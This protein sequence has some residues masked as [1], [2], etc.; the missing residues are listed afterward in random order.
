MIILKFKFG[1]VEFQ[2]LTH[3]DDP[4]NWQSLDIEFKAK[5]LKNRKLLEFNSKKI[6]LQGYLKDEFDKV[7]HD[8]LTR[9]IV[10]NIDFSISNEEDVYFEGFVSFK[11]IEIRDKVTGF[12]ALSYKGIHPKV[13]EI[14]YTP[15]NS[16]YITTNEPLQG[17][18]TVQ[19]TKDK[20]Y[21]VSELAI[22]DKETFYS[23]EIND[24]TEY[25]FLRVEKGTTKLVANDI[26]YNIQTVYNTFYNKVRFALQME[27]NPSFIEF[28]TFNLRF[29]LLI[30]NSKTPTNPY[31]EKIFLN[32]HTIKTGDYEYNEDLNTFDFDIDVLI[33]LTTGV[34]S[35]DLDTDTFLV[36][37]SVEI[38]NLRVKVQA[39]PLQSVGVENT[40]VLS[41][42]SIQ[43]RFTTDYRVQDKLYFVSSND[44]INEINRQG[45]TDYNISNNF[46]LSSIDFMTSK[47]KNLTFNVEDFINDIALLYGKSITQ[48]QKIIS[49][50]EIFTNQKSLSIV[51]NSLKIGQN[52]DLLFDSVTVGKT[53]KANEKNKFDEFTDK[54]TYHIDSLDMA[55]TEL[56]LSIKSLKM[57]M[58]NVINYISQKRQEYIQIAKGGF[59]LDISISKKDVNF[60]DLSFDESDKLLIFDGGSHHDSIHNY[61][62]V[63]MKTPSG[64]SINMLNYTYAPQTVLNNWSW[65]I[66][67]FNK[68]PTL[69]GG[70][71]NNDLIVDN[72]SIKDPLID[73]NP[74][75]TSRVLIV[76]AVL[77][78]DDYLLIKENLYG[79]I[80][81]TYN[82][83]I[84]SGYIDTIAFPLYGKENSTIQ[85]LERKQ[86][87]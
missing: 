33:N 42:K 64:G 35:L 43:S 19:P 22:K 8:K 9:A 25:P 85:L 11:S 5:S 27:S 32:S 81:F 3:A 16:T 46:L 68:Q 82:D 31:S 4:I 63:D 34:G 2:S 15:I 48:A 17:S 12:L 70:T 44:V 60:Q 26:I 13:K 65:L 21:S 7:Y 61:V 29:K 69:Q 87:P 20:I 24:P 47:G 67:I 45:N 57:D 50:D 52:T 62:D 80:E 79:Y 30:F 74:L 75:I 86:T 1:A 14:T 53:S 76:Q 56:N 49:F 28:F 40:F 59:V 77:S 39:R 66:G 83:V 23:Y 54:K 36:G 55:N 10:D 84:Y 78:V 58:T 6:Q 73:N 38:Y 72:N 71:L 51:A 41:L 37:F 18:T